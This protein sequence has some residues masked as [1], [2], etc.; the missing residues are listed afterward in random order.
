MYGKM[1]I[2]EVIAQLGTNVQTGLSTVAADKLRLQHGENVLRETKRESVFKLFLKQ[3]KDAMV[4][5]LLAAACASFLM[6][7]LSGSGDYVDPILILVIVVLNAVIATTQEYRA[8]KALE[9]LKSMSAPTVEVVRDG[10]RVRIESTQVVV[11]DVFFLRAGDL[12]PADA[13]L[14]EA[15]EL[16]TDEA[17][18]TGESQAVEKHTYAVQSG[19]ES[20]M[21]WAS[22]VVVSGHGKAV[23]VQTGMQTRVGKIAGLLQES[24]PPLTPLQ[25]KLARTGKMLGIGALGICLLVFV[26]GLLR[27]YPPM[28]IF[29]TSV[30]LAVAAIPEGLV[31]IVTILLATGTSA[32]AR[33]NAIVKRLPAVETLGSATVI[34]S[35]KTGTLT[36]N[37]MTVTEVYGNRDLVL[38]LAALCNN[39][40]GSTEL[41]IL[42]AAQKNGFVRKTMEGAYARVRENPF[43]S[44]KKYMST[45]HRTESGYRLIVKG[46]PD[47]LLPKCALGAQAHSDILS[48]QRHMAA[49]ALRVL[50]VAYKDVP[51]MTSASEDNLVFAGLIGM[52][53]PPRPEAARAVA[54]CRQAGIRVVMITGDHADTACAIA[55]QLGIYTAEDEVMTGKELAQLSEEAL[56]EQIECYSVFAR[57]TPEQ[58]VK[59]VRA[60]QLRR[61]VVA[62]TGDGVNDA[63]ALKIADIGCA[64]GKSGTSVAKEAADLV[65]TDDHFATIVSAVRAGRTIY[66]NISKAVRFLLSSNIGEI[67]TVFV[68]MFVGWSAPLE[69][70]HLLWI[71]LVTDALPAIALGFEPAPADIMEQKPIGRGAGL[72]ADG[73]GVAVALEGIMIGTL[74]LVSFS[75]GMYVFGDYAVAQT[76]AFCVLSLSQ[77]VHAY[78]M[79][80]SRSVFHIGIF[81]NKRLNVSFVICVALQVSVVACAPLRSIFRVAAL[82]GVQWGI[83]FLLSLLPL[84]L[85]EMQKFADMLKAAKK[86]TAS[87]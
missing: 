19:E 4:L 42:E 45:L 17:A 86:R 16:C 52:I 64:M 83:V 67:L 84:A 20:N 77:L 8:G 28:E 22:T 80:S 82:S 38:D 72:F 41:A 18:L 70:I 14:L 9:E 48:K 43:N 21:V 76:M 30:S 56:A 39:E 23:V 75:F 57:V 11:G 49:K 5:V 1:Q 87:A 26:M 27:G 46:A 78:N 25:E 32:M 10:K 15:T 47:V 65:L 44:E 29:M 66:G 35:D 34:C 74:T 55:A 85:V 13:R 58:K 2:Q 37:K 54:L 62:M 63:P 6:A 12:V 68:A 79:R 36:Q 31:T 33:R 59:I 50:A 60:F 73:A 7:L 3:F 69:A 61:A 40:T 71:N 24:V 53:D 81:R 51:D